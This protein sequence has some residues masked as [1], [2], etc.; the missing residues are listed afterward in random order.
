MIRQ[1]R[2]QRVEPE[3]V[4][5]QPAPELLCSLIDQHDIAALL[6]DINTLNLLWSSTSALQLD[7][8]LVAG[9]NLSEDV[10]ELHAVLSGPLQAAASDM[11]LLTANNQSAVLAN[12]LLQGSRQRVVQYATVHPSDASDGVQTQKEA[13]SAQITV[14]S[15]DLSDGRMVSIRSVSRQ[16]NVLLLQ[17]DREQQMDNYYREY[18]ADRE[19]LFNTSRA[20]TVNEMATTLAHEL[21]QP[22]GTVV[23]LLHGCLERLQQH[24]AS[25]K[26]VAEEQIGGDVLEAMDFAIRQSRFASQ[27]IARIREF[28]EARQP[29]M[30]QLDLRELVRESVDLLDW[31]IASERIHLSLHGGESPLKVTCDR[32]LLQ[33]VLVNLC[34]NAIEAMRDMVH[35]ERHLNIHLYRSDDGVHIDIVDTGPGMSDDL[36]GDMF[37]PFVSSKRDGMGVGLNIC[38]SFVELHQ[39]RLWV[40]SNQQQGCTVHIRLPGLTTDVE[41][42]AIKG[43]AL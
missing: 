5:M 8:R 35:G 40:T 41:S 15:D 12:C 7:D 31:V 19:K 28:T 22:I 3:P 37:K 33:Q 11:N 30:E 1:T 14:D 18:V 24:N 13:T 21:N 32:M 38:R 34:R 17:I 43:G 9:R 10:P 27:I 26:G 20:L 6:V 25:K 4:N 42:D 29:S 23:N 16:G 2:N 36:L 39:G